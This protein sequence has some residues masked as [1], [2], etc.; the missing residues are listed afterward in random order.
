MLSEFPAVTVQNKCHILTQVNNAHDSIITEEVL[1]CSYNGHVVSGSIQ[2]TLQQIVVSGVITNIHSVTA[3]T[4][5]IGYDVSIST[6]G[7]SPGHSDTSGT[8]LDCHHICGS[9][10]NCNIVDKHILSYI[11]MFYLEQ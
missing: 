3:A 10:C 1:G 8:F 5:S 6:N 9:F 4:S 11:V 2:K 7:W